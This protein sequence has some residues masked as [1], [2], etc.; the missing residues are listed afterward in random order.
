MTALPDYSAT[1]IDDYLQ[2]ERAA[3]KRHE[4]FNGE[5]C[6]LAGASE[7]HNLIASAV[8]YTLYGGTIERNCRVFQSDMRVQAAD[9]SVFYPDVVVVCGEAHYRDD[10]RDTLLNPTLIVEVLSPSTEDIDRGRKFAAYRQIPSLQDYL[11]IAQNTPRIEHYCRTDDR[12]MLKD[13]TSLSAT[14]DLPA[15]GCALSLQAVYRQ[16]DFD[17]E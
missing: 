15:V 14:I 12:W 2:A 10:R 5:I 11:L 16:V 13:I 4:Y 6:A 1:T 9:T 8:Q 7:R 3:T 17:T